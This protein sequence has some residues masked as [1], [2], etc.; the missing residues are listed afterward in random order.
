[1]TYTTIQGDTWDIIAYKLF[2]VE[3]RM[4]L[5]M[6]TNPDHISTVIFSAGV[7]LTIPEIPDAVSAELPPWKQ[8]AT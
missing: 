4:L 8:V 7:A 6:Q 2:G 1:M 3:S 5:L